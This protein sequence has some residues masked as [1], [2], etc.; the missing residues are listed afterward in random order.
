[1]SI[2]IKRNFQGNCIEFQGS[3]N[4][5]YWNACLSGETDPIRPEL[6]NVINDIK[7]AG[8]FITEYEFFNIPYTEFRDENGTDFNSAAECAAYITEKGNVTEVNFHVITNDINTYDVTSNDDNMTVVM[9]YDGD[10]SVILPDTATLPEDLVVTII[11]KVSNNNVGSIIPYGADQIDFSGTK[12]LFGKAK[13]ELVNKNGKWIISDQSSFIDEKDFGRSKNISFLNQS[14]IVVNHGSGT[15]P[16]VDVY[17]E[18][19]SAQ[20]VHANV[21]ITHD[22]NLKNSFTLNFESPQNGL[23]VYI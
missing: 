3:S 9:Q 7:T 2:I 16:I 17:V 12:Q 8:S 5:V 13:I 18:N 15:I 22:F 20:F 6:I 23:I 14:Q 1:M 4:P 19:D 11:H 21:E 10:Y